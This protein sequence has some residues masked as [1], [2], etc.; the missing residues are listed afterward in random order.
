MKQQKI[1]LHDGDDQRLIDLAADFDSLIKDVQK[2]T[3]VTSP[4]AI[5]FLRF[6]VLYDISNELKC[7][8]EH[9]EA[10]QN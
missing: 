3:R 8:R 10:G 2:L 7:I 5:E 9:L 6:A 4:Q 1:R